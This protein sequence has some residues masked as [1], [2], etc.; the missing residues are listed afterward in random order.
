MEEKF[1]AVV[2]GGGPAGVSAAL[3]LTRANIRTAIVE[4]GPG[5]LARAKKIDN[6]YGAA[7]SGPR[8]YAE[9]IE[10]ARLLGAVIL[11]DEVLDLEYINGF[12][13]TLKNAQEPLT[14][15]VLIL[16]TGA[17][18]VSLNLP[19]LAQ[20]E[21][22]GVSYCA[23][24]DGFFFRGK[25]VAVVGAGSYALHEAEYL[26]HLAASVTILTNGGDDILAR[27]AGF[28]VLS[29]PLAKL[30]GNV[31]L[32]SVV[33]ADGSELPV[34]GLFVAL[35]T[36]DSADM[37]RKLGAQLNGRFIKI[38]PDGSTNIPGLFAAGDCTGG[39]MQVAKAVYEGA[40]AAL[41]AVEFIRGK[42]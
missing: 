19:G 1:Q 17:K 42:K 3:Y 35:G 12:A 37:A 26:K 6:Y 29:Q 9:G 34:D 4:N 21:G 38:N 27:K 24:C 20:L 7:T 18:S 30:R 8:L 23:V 40:R 16:A 5:A 32:Q 11:Q 15:Q 13:L 36:A 14:A 10:Q 31:K 22:R 28:T 33:F 2:I 39:L 25:R 41:A